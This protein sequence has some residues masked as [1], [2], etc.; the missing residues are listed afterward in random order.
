MSLKCAIFKIY[1]KLAGK[2]YSCETRVYS[3]IFGDSW[4]QKVVSV[5][6][7]GN[8]KSQFFAPENAHF[9]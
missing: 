6:G 2:L 3:T 8:P 9:Q 5:F 7:F 1:P 4:R